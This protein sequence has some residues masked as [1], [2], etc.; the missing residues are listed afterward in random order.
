MILDAED[1]VRKD[2]YIYVNMYVCMCEALHKIIFMNTITHFYHFRI[3]NGVNLVFNAT[4][5]LLVVFS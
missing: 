5:Y 1:V 3:V 4:I 2:T